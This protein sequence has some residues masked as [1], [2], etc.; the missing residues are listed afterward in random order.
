MLFTPLKHYVQATELSRGS[1]E[2]LLLLPDVFEFKLIKLFVHGKRGNLRVLCLTIIVIRKPFSQHWP[3]SS[4]SYFM[5]N[6]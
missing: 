4:A 3:L 6:A 1:Y 5:L 2:A